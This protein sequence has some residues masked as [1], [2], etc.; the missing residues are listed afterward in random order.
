MDVVRP[1]VVEVV[2]NDPTAYDATT[3]RGNR[4]PVFREHEHRRQCEHDEDQDQDPHDIP[5]LPYRGGMSPI[6][7]PE[8]RRVAAVGAIVRD[9]SGRLL[10]IRRAQD[11]GKGLWSIPGGRIEPGETPE[12]AL[13]REVSEETG[14]EVTVGKLVGSVE[15]QGVSGDIY[16]IADYE[17]ALVGGTLR[18]ATDADDARWVTA[19]ELRQLELT[20]LLSETLRNWQVI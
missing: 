8:K 16:E 18:A 10:V 19:D 6:P 3:N 13:A 12:D 11:P 20:P 14:L 17:C 4:S 15:R 1:V 7:G 2:M 9:E 5:V